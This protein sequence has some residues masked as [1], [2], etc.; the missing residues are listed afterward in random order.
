MSEKK[1]IRPKIKSIQLTAEEDRALDRLAEL[2]KESRSGVLRNITERVAAGDV[3]YTPTGRESAKLFQYWC[4][5]ETVRKAQEV[6]AE[7]GSSLREMIHSELL[8]M[9]GVTD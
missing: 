4:E 2:T 3:Y 6:A 8:R 7:R 5:P 1:P 9:A